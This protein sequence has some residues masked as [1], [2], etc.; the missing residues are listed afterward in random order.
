MNTE[1]I[2]KSEMSS[3]QIKK[4]LQKRAKLLQKVEKK[5]EHK[6]KQIDG[7]EF[8]LADERY[9]IDSTYVSEVIS[10]NNLTDLPC[11]P[12]FILGIINVRGEILSVIDI[13]KFFNL[14]E[15]EISN[16][17]KVML[18]KYK[19]IMLGILVDEII[20][21]TNIYLETLQEK[22]NTITE[23]LKNFIIGVSEDRLIVLDIK[24]LLSS[25]KIIIN[26]EV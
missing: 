22:V 10:M 9:A 14:P 15:K 5:S 19:D 16:I 12:A 7:L 8:L 2:N 1:I 26:E 13:K 4:T 11:T 6:G 21:N 3:T 20:G 25:D 18:V 24:E 17:K 23:L